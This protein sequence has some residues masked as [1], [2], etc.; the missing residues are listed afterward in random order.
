MSSICNRVVGVVN[1]VLFYCFCTSCL[2]VYIKDS[3]S[4]MIKVILRVLVVILMLIVLLLIVV[5]VS[6]V[7]VEIGSSNC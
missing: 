4:I 5:V 7:I 3:K 1:I 2:I 6:V